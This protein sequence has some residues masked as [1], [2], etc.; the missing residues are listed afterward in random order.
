MNSYLIRLCPQ[1]LIQAEGETGEWAI[2]QA[3][4]TITT[5]ISPWAARKDAWVVSCKGDVDN[6]QHPFG[7]IHRP[8]V[9]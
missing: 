7:D 8:E 1:F 9:W 2:I 4:G 5:D 6:E 3:A